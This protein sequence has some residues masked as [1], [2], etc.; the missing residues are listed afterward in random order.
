VPTL[1]ELIF[2][3]SGSVVCPT[4]TDPLSNRYAEAR[5]AFT[6]VARRGSR[7]ELG[8]VLHFDQSSGEV[9]PLP[10]TRSG[11]VTL[12][13][14]LRLPPDGAGSSTLTPSLRR[15]VE[16]TEAYPEHAATLV[17]L[18]DF[19]LFD[20]DEVYTELAAFPGTVHAV[21]LGGHT[22]PKLTGK[23]VTVTKVGRTDPPGSVAKAVFASLTTHRPGSRACPAGDDRPPRWRQV[24]RIPQRLPRS[25]GTRSPDSP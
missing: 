10:L 14:G 12:R 23:N 19:Y 2:D 15:A 18:S 24:L 11:L 25:P 21:V 9:G 4:G 17:V 1:L 7:R 5:R 20:P 6:V 8:A 22:V 16:I 3:N 13:R